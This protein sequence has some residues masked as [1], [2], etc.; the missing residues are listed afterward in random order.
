MED[1]IDRIQGAIIKPTGVLGALL[2]AAYALYLYWSKS[3]EGYVWL[4]L[5]YGSIGG[6]VGVG[7]AILAMNIVLYLIFGFLY[8]LKS[9]PTILFVGGKG[10]AMIAI[11]LLSLW[12]L[13]EFLGYQLWNR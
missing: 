10:G 12:L 9:L 4:V 5:L 13:L 2:G 3:D 8:F 6:F 11:V 1:A 7:A